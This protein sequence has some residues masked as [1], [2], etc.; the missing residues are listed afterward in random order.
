MTLS[1]IKR[2]LNKDNIDEA[3]NNYKTLLA[4]VPLIIEEL[5]LFDLLKK[6][7]REKI[8]RGP[9]PEVSIFEASNRIMTDLVILF[10]IKKIL[11]GEV[12]TLKEFTNF[13]V[14][15]GNENNNPHDII[16]KKGS[17]YLAGEAFNVAPSFFQGKKSSSIKKLINS[18]PPPDYLILLCNDDSHKPVIKTKIQKHSV[19]I[20]RVKIE[21]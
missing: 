11:L 16:S 6:L 21:L 3:I 18:N 19:E 17:K 1:E 8:G 5:N 10:G 4:D 12:P 15:F 2:D 9:Y 14:E 7:K 13:K 20:I